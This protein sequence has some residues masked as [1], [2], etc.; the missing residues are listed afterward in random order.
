MPSTP[1]LLSQNR[2]LSNSIL[3]DKPLCMAPPN[4]SP[5]IQAWTYKENAGGNNLWRCSA[6]SPL[7]GLGERLVFLHNNTINSDRPSFVHRY[8]QHVSKPHPQSHPIKIIPCLY[9]SHI[10][11]YLKKEFQISRERKAQTDHNKK[12]PVSPVPRRSWHQNWTQKM[13]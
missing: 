13:Y 3:C 1:S 10:L 6:A 12:T 4:R 5:F 9:I 2:G 7:A 8:K 11:P